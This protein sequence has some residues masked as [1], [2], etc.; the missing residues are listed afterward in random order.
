MHQTP[1]T[2]ADQRRDKILDAA[3]G[4]FGRFGFQKTSVQDLADAV[5]ISKPGLYLHFASK[6]DIFEAAMERY[7]T[8]ALDQLCDELTKPKRSLPDRLVAAMEAWFGRHL[9]TFTP[10]AFDVIEAGD[11]LSADW[12]ADVKN[13]FRQSVA[14]AF[15]TEGYAKGAAYKRAEMLF[16]CGLSWKL[17]GT[18][19]EIFRVRMKACIDVCCGH[20]APRQTESL[21]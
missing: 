6:D 5:S 19:P 9:I 13:V 18:T 14:Q 17:P 8:N 12:V 3:M 4:V 1:A 15:Q 16:L 7:L 21:K 2:I 11:R 10:D 20:D